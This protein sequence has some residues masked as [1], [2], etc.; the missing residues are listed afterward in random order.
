MIELTNPSPLP[1]GIPLN[2]AYNLFL[3]FTS[4]TMASGVLTL[5]YLMASD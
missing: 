5:Q 3:S 1:L 4:L 2:S